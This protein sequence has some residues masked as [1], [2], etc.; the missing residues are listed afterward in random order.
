MIAAEAYHHTGMLLIST[1][2]CKKKS[3]FCIKPSAIPQGEL[4]IKMEDV[5]NLEKKKGLNRNLKNFLL[6]IKS[7]GFL[8]WEGK[9][10]QDIVKMRKKS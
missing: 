9:I 3:C 6:R 1:F 2:M 4:R 8:K 10:L 7:V 5:M